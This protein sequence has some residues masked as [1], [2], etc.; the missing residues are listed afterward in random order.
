V[1]GDPMNQ[2]W[3]VMDALAVTDFPDV[4]LKCAIHSAQG[5][6]LIIPREGGC[7]VRFYVELDNV[8]DKEM[9]ENRSVTPEKLTAVA[10]RIQHPYTVEVKDV[11]WWSVYEIGQRLCDKFDDVPVAEMATRLPRVFIAGDACHTHSAKA[12]QGM[13]VSM[14][15][16]WKTSGRAA[17]RSGRLTPDAGQAAAEIDAQGP[18]PAATLPSDLGRENFDTW[19]EFCRGLLWRLPAPTHADR[20]LTSHFGVARPFSV[21]TGLWRSGWRRSVDHDRGSLRELGQNRV[22]H[23]RRT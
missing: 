8:R 13:N 23:S 17:A 5:N 6:I 20:G 19:A 16:T 9:L 10:N 11:G 21:V 3:G 1:V 4:R 14:N 18:R 2:S 12:G 7:L 15:D 22:D